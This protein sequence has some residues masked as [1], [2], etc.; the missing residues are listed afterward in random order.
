MFS[1]IKVNNWTMNLKRI[2]I[3]Y[4]DAAHKKINTSQLLQVFLFLFTVTVSLSVCITF[5]YKDRT[6]TDYFSQ[7]TD[8]YSWFHIGGAM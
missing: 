1:I 8:T 6:N 5:G 4:I 3:T 7:D 2:C